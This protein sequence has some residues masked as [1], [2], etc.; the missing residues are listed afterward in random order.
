MLDMTQRRGIWRTG[1]GLMPERE[2]RWAKITGIGTI[3][4]VLLAAGGYIIGGGSGSSS[5]T[6]STSG[7]GS[8]VNVGSTATVSNSTSPST[9]SAASGICTVTLS[10]VARVFAS[11]SPTAASTS[12]PAGSYPVLKKEQVGFGGANLEWYEI[13]VQH[14]PGWVPDEPGET[15][16]NTCGLP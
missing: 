2:G 7:I 1:V 11:P 8:T 15:T 12:A 10:P 14:Q 9:G 5:T 13:S 3:V 6:A 16:A 4:L